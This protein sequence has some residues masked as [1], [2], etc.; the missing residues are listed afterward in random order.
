MR[1][2]VV[3][4][5]GAQQL[6]AVG[7]V[8]HALAQRL[9]DALH[10]AAL[11]LALHDVRADDAP[12]VVHRGV[13]H[14]LDAAGGGVD[15]DLGDVAAVGPAGRAGLGRAVG[16]DA[17]LRLPRR[18]LEQPDAEVGAGDAE[19]ARA[20]LDVGG[21]R[22]QRVGRE[23]PALFDR[24]L[25]RHAHGRAAGEQRPAAGAAEAVGAVGVALQH[26]DL[27]QRHA[28]DVVRQL[29]VAGGDA[30]AHRHRGRGQ[31][32]VA[33]GGDVHLHRF[34]ERVAAGPLQERG[35]AA[36]A[37]PPARLRRRAARR[38]AA[39]VGQRQALVEHLREGAVVVDLAHRV[40]VREL[41]A[42]DHVAAAQFGRVDL[43]RARGGVE[44]A[45]GGVDGLGPAGAAVG[46]GGSGVR[47]HR[48]QVQVDQRDVVDAGRD[49]G[50]D[51]QLDRDAGGAGVGT[52]VGQRADAQREH[53]AV[54]VERH[55][56]VA[57]QVAAGSGAEEVFHALGLPLHRALQVLGREG[58]HHVLGVDAGLHAE[59][60]ADVAHHHAHGL[61]AQA[62]DG[63][64]DAGAHGGRHLA[65]QPHGEAAVVEAGEHA[66]RLHRAG[67][68]ALVHQVELHAVRGTREGGVDRGG[69]A[70]AGLG[71]DVVGHAFAQQRRT[72]GDGALGV[73]HRGQRF[74][75]HQ[76]GIGRGAR[77]LAAGGDDGHHRLADV[78]HHVQRQ[79]ALGR[80]G[81]RLA[82]GAL[83]GR[84]QQHRLDAGGHQ[85][86]AGV[87][88][89]HAGQRARRRGVDGQQLRVRGARAHEAQE[90]L[91]GGVDVVGEAALP[92]HQGRVLDAA[93]A[94]AAAE[95]LGLERRVHAASPACCV[96]S[97]F[98][99]TCTA[100][101]MF[102]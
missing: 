79:R 97:V 6:A 94:V 17:R 78:P 100:A 92:L 20:V 19:A 28:E 77:S 63:I 91:A 26:A 21:R 61:G 3:H 93:H 47:Q 40:L 7:V 69:V 25:G 5:A 42:P 81:H 34:L 49:P 13:G 68:Q 43:H 32:D 4:V 67:G 39:P 64:D 99:A 35:D 80:R 83:E 60:A 23:L 70:V 30:L 89:H 33:V 90:G 54:G 53:A 76:H 1:Q 2:R 36:P 11:D 52:H 72:G 86:G 9:A 84:R 59:A 24:A 51:Q 87:D 10:R 31:L 18:Q 96:R 27:L 62:G 48:G 15:L 65:R 95:A 46:A 16:D 75:L 71:D 45:L 44:Q 98:A 22:L 29:H 56:G 73:H 88:R 74:D 82:V 102:T 41:L 12:D 14:D 57:H 101:T 55:L 66:A 85:V 38:E 50:A 8:G 37:Q 58:H